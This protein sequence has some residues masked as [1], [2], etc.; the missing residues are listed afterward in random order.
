MNFSSVDNLVIK[1][2]GSLVR[3]FSDTDT[4]TLVVFENTNSPKVAFIP[5]ITLNLDLPKPIN[6]RVN[7][8]Q[9]TI[10][11]DPRMVK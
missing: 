7:L 4:I 9:M 3:G 5:V 2:T 6:F 10:D 8:K 11:T 1:A